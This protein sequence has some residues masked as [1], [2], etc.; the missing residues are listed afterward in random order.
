MGFRASSFP[1]PGKT[2]LYLEDPAAGP[3]FGTRPGD[4]IGLEVAVPDEDAR[5]FYIPGCA[6][7]P[8]DL[9]ERLDGAKLLFFDGT[10]WHDDEMLRA[11]LGEKTGRSEEHTS[12]LQSLMRISYAVFSLKKKTQPKKVKHRN[13]RTKTS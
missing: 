12:E 7:M 2:A 6:A 9:A 11:G 5:F 8:P 10:L 3:D 4:S 1:V 13:Q